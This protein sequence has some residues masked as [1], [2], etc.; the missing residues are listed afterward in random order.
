[1][2]NF[3]TFR[4]P[5]APWRTQ[6]MGALAFSCHLFRVPPGRKTGAL[7]GVAHIGLDPVDTG[8]DSYS[9]LLVVSPGS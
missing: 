7:G 9:P 1:M 2:P 4:G 3:T 8:E 5:I 6:H